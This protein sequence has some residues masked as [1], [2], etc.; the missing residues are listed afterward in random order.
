MI[1]VF[2]RPKVEARVYDRPLQT[3]RTLIDAAIHV[4]QEVVD[5]VRPPIPGE[6]TSLDYQGFVRSFSH[7]VRS[8]L[9][10]HAA[11]GRPSALAPVDNRL[12]AAQACLSNTLLGV[13]LQ[14]T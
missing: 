8:E 11:V 10:T 2:S 14:S 5:P 6:T 13:L 1:S 12:L 3:S 9:T 4:G 7:L